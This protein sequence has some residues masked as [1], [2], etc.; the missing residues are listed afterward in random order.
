LK[1]HKFHFSNLQFPGKEN[2]NEAL[3]IKTNS[4]E[5]VSYAGNLFTDSGISGA[6]AGHPVD[7]TRPDGGTFD[8]RGGR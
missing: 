6:G 2:A 5:F 8:F 4:I 1:T 3:S 7:P